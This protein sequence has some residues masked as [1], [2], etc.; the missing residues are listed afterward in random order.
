[1]LLCASKMDDDKKASEK[2][3]VKANGAS[4]VAERDVKDAFLSPPLS[5]KLSI[6]VKGNPLKSKLVFVPCQ[7]KRKWI[8]IL[9]YAMIIWHFYMWRSW[10]LKLVYI[11]WYM[12]YV[13]D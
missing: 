13:R 9:P 8:I 3:H 7:N 5:I 2:V 10:F 12:R 1:M 4:K 6:M 11:F